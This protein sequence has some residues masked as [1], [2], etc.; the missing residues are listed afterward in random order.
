MN[1]A[2]PEQGKAGRRAIS[3]SSEQFAP[4]SPLVVKWFTTYSRRYIQRHFHS[5]RVSREH[6]PSMDGAC[7]PV[8]YL[9]HASWWDP[10]VLLLITNHFFPDRKFF[11]PMDEKALERY[12]FFRRIGCFGI[13]LDSL[14]GARQ[15]LSASLAALE[16][17]GGGL[18]ITPQGRFADVRERPLH[19]GTGLGQ[20]AL[21]S[22]QA[23]FIPLA[24]EYV[25]W[26]E[27]LPEVLSRF[28][29]PISGAELLRS[30][31]SEMGADSASASACTRLLEERLTQSQDALAADSISREATRFH[32]LLAGGAGV[33]GVYDRW[34]RFRCWMRGERFAPEHSSL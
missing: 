26:E 13:E 15:F 11:A 28:G 16:I 1:S 19:F 22:P 33:G 32:N 30:A 4:Y 2:P 18:C 10:L 31:Q 29:E 17:P 6:V 23:M 14:R 25:F 5:V 21:R 24:L 27:R 9:N 20:L 8:I 3:A 34:R 7:T 12:G